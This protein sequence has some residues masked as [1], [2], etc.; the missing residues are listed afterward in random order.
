[1]LHVDVISVAAAA[2]EV[3]TKRVGRVR[4][5]LWNR[6]P[7]AQLFDVML[8]TRAVHMS[9]DRVP[10]R[11]ASQ[12]GTFSVR[13]LLGDYVE[14]KP[15]PPLAYVGTLSGPFPPYTEARLVTATD[16]LGNALLLFAKNV[17]GVTLSADPQ[18]GSR[19]HILQWDG[20]RFV[21]RSLQ[22]A[23]SAG[24]A[25]SSSSHVLLHANNG[26]RKRQERGALLCLNYNHS[27]VLRKH[28]AVL[29]PVLVERRTAFVASSDAATVA[30]LKEAASALMWLRATDN[31]D[32]WKH[33]A[34]APQARAI[35]WDVLIGELLEH[36]I[37]CPALAHLCLFGETPPLSSAASAYTLQHA[38]SA[39]VPPNPGLGR[40]AGDNQLYPGLPDKKPRFGG[41]DGE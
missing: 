5:S 11:D 32:A 23:P 10:L 40:A 1:M 28:L 25:L 26:R 37:M 27:S 13:L 35:A 14:P 19:T 18:L 4:V 30:Q 6:P 33:L 36:Q 8:D 3:G 34:D 31:E 39:L 15:M 17:R 2:G 7:P 16:K 29:V 21:L 20:N 12:Q 22:A 9:V 41:G 38:V 24:G